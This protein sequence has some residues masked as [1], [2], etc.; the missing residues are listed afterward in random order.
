MDVAKTLISLSR[1]KTL[2]VMCLDAFVR[3][4]LDGEVEGKL[5]G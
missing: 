1:G 4:G 3:G 5:D 2:I